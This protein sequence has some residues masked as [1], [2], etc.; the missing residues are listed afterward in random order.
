MPEKADLDKH[1]RFAENLQKKGGYWGLFPTADLIG[2]LLHEGKCVYCDT[3]LVDTYHMTNGLGGTD[4]L[5]PKIKYPELR[6]DPL[7]LVP[8]CAGC[9]GIKRNW[10]A[11][12]QFSPPLYQQEIGGGIKNKD[13][14]DQLVLK[15]R[16]EVD[17]KR[18]KRQ[19]TFPTDQANWAN[20]IRQLQTP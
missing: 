1:R 12:E 13:I 20:A 10:D 9:N 7:N 19:Q 15:A 14:H 5:L 4:H 17:K 16:E 2:W 8:A 18:R 11:N 3:P 6:D